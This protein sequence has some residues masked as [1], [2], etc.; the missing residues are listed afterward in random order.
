MEIPKEIYQH[1]RYKEN[2]KGK[3]KEKTFHEYR[4]NGFWD[5]PAGISLVLMSDLHSATSTTVDHLIA[6]NIINKKTI[7]I[8]TGDM[9]GNDKLGGDADPYNDY[10][11]LKDASYLYYLVQGNH[12]TYNEKVF[13]LKNEDGSP[14]CLHRKVQD[15]PIGKIAGINGVGYDNP[16]VV[17]I[18]K[19]KYPEQKYNNH[20]QELLMEYKPDILLTHPPIKH[21]I[22]NKWHMPKYHI[23]GHA[24]NDNYFQVDNSGEHAMLNLDCRI[25]WFHN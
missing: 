9:A 13:E 4:N 1:S 22:L 24:H 23:F 10:C 19:H 2:L 25:M 5:L 15:T 8:S 7:V 17:N 12:D 20:L 21:S 11:K 16:S 6:K 3:V 14:C 18:A